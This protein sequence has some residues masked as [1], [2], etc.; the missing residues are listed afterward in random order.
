MSDFF[1]IVLIGMAISVAVFAFGL[2]QVHFYITGKNVKA[3]IKGVGA[4]KFKRKLKTLIDDFRYDLHQ[5]FLSS[6][7]YENIF[8]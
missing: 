6:L 1:T 2:I 8:S 3:R 7:R 4:V 5:V